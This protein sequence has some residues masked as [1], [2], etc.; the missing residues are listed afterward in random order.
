[1]GLFQEDKGWLCK[2]MVNDEW[3]F[4]QV[5]GWRSAISWE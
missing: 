4:V 5:K 2:K 1:M 3:V